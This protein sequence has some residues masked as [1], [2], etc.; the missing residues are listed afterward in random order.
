MF[1][2]VNITKQDR[3]ALILID[4]QKGFDDIEYWGGHRNNPEAEFNA[5]KLLNFWRQNAL[6]ILH[7]KHCSSNPYSPLAE[8]NI[9]NDFKEIVKP[10]DGELIIKKNVNSAFI[11][12]DLKQQLENSKIKKVVIVGLTTDQCIST[13]TRMSGNYGFDTFLVSDATATFDKI[14]VNGQKFSAELI[15]D[16]ALASLNNEFAVVVKAEDLINELS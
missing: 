8:G 7:V 9:G 12:T 2:E 3:P 13:T 5:S 14:G 4:I 6:P 1:K 10:Y 16:T 15:H 11:G